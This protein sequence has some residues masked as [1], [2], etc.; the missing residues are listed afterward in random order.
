MNTIGGTMTRTVTALAR[1]TLPVVF[2]LLPGIWSC[3]GHAPAADQQ[4]QAP[5]VVGPE[6]VV[7]VDSTTVVS[8]PSF[9]G[10]LMA[11]NSAT[12]RS[13]V[14]G[15]VERTYAEEGQKV[16]RG[17]PLL[18]IDAAAI[19][20]AAQSARSAVQSAQAA[21]TLAQRNLERSQALQ[22]AGAVAERDVETA[23][24]NAE[25]AQAALAE[26]KSRLATAE[27][28]LANTEPRSPFG[29]V[30]SDR[31]VNQGDVVQ[32]GTALVTVV[33][34]SSLRLEAS[35]PAAALA[36]LRVGAPVDFTVS[37]FG[38]RSF[39]GTV[40]RV[41]PVVD[42]ATRQARIYV[43]IPNADRQLAAGLFAEGRVA[44]Q[45]RK[46]IAVPQRALDTRAGPPS[47][48]R[49]RGGTVERVPVQTGLQDDLADMIEVTQGLRAG[50]TVLAGTAQ[51]IPSG[52]RIEVEA[53]AAPPPADSA[54]A[55]VGH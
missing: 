55:A 53:P 36:R 43:R 34:P 8:G 20:D 7:P 48:L 9:S 47:V 23:R 18:S 12:I 33:D 46:T 45:S 41:N 17:A 3:G 6:N 32:P 44:L 51:G 52:A 4:E 49:V 15:T 42:P 25:N 19:R 11:E 37:G 27:K 26:T 38:D 16:A 31:P 1:R 30:V 5:V 2:L 22:Q 29:G 13:Q 10:Q 21:A 50:D 40:E 54:A 39:S 24:A 14:S 28:N 35:V